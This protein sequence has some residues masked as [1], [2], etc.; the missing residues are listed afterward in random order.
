M[1][2]TRARSCA[3]ADDAKSCAVGMRNAKPGNHLKASSV[4][5]KANPVADALSRFQFQRFR[6]LAPLADLAA[7]PVPP[8]LLEVLLVT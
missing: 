1:F 2:C 5:G 6:R 8:D 7:T 3:R 4:P